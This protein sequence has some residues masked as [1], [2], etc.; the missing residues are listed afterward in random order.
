[1][2][3]PLPILRLRPLTR[4]DYPLLQH[5][6]AQPH[7]KR[8]WDHEFSDEAVEADFGACIDG[9]EP[10]DL[11]IGM[12]GDEAVGLIQRYAIA[13][14]PEYVEELLP[15]VEMPDGVFSIDYFIGEPARLRQGLG[16]ALIK[17]CVESI[18]RDH[19]SVGSVIVPVN[20][21]NPGSWRVLERAGF[22]RVAQGE[23]TPDNPIDDRW[24]WVYR[25]DRED[26]S[27]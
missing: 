1:M 9:L 27:P 7:V 6:L 11:F 25:V 18:W 2:K 24:H 12:V 4:A 19:P 20:A 10:T 3:P 21:S 15:V 26:E 16:A 5:W 13:S 22:R 17:A 23:L 14:Y 8:W